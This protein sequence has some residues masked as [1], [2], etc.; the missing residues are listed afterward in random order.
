MERSRK[1]EMK[2]IEEFRL[3]VSVKADG[4]FN[5]FKAMEAKGVLEK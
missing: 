2:P 4:F 3:V 5:L 1:L